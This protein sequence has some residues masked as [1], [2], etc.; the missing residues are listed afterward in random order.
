[1]ACNFWK[2]LYA[3]LFFLLPLNGLTMTSQLITAPLSDLKDKENGR[4]LALLCKK[5]KCVYS[6]LLVSASWMQQ[7]GKWI[8][9]CWRHGC[10]H[11]ACVLQWQ[12]EHWGRSEDRLDLTF[13]ELPQ[14]QKCY[15][16]KWNHPQSSQCICFSFWDCWKN[17]VEFFNLLPSKHGPSASCADYICI[18][19]FGPGPCLYTCMK[20]KS[21]LVFGHQHQHSVQNLNV[22]L[23]DVFGC[24][25]Q[26]QR[27]GKSSKIQLQSPFVA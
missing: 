26:V 4:A 17:I 22:W 10:H 19:S 1:M 27:I 20:W 11:F 24:R 3:V 14:K 7:N 23:G 9:S 5:E 18:P 12:R 16:G 8:I 21:D 13:E 25:R 15:L 2:H 6:C